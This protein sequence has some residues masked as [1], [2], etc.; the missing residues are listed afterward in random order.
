MG[1]AGEGTA[2]IGE[3][4]FGL[5]QFLQRQCEE[6]AGF[7]GG[8]VFGTEGALLNGEDGAPLLRGGCVFAQG[9]EIFGLLQ[10]ELQGLWIFRAVEVRGDGDPFLPLLHCFGVFLLKSEVL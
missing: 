8:F 9:V 5:L 4:F 7:Q 1:A 6:V 10:A 3:G 2:G